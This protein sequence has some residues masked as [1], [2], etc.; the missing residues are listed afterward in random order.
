MRAVFFLDK[1][2]PAE[3]SFVDDFLN[4]FFRSDELLLVYQKALT[5]RAES[6]DTLPKNSVVA[7]HPRRGIKRFTNIF[8]VFRFLQQ[9]KKFETI[10]VR[11]CP[12]MLLGA[13]FFCLSRGRR[14]P[15][16]V[17]M[18]S[19]DHEGTAKGLKRWIALKLHSV[20][21]RK[22][23]GLLTVSASGMSRVRKLY[24]FASTFLVIPLCASGQV[25][26]DQDMKPACSRRV[27]TFIYG[28]SFNQC[29]KFDLVL[30]AFESMLVANRCKLLLVGV[31]D[32]LAADWINRYPFC[33]SP[34]VKFLSKL[35]RRDFLNLL[36]SA[37]FGLSLVPSSSVNDEMSPTKL[38]EYFDYSLPA[39]ASENVE[40]QR[41]VISMYGAGILTQ[42]RHQDIE[43][44]IEQAISA[45]VE[46]Y[47]RLVAGAQAAASAF[48]YAAY[49][50]P[51]RTLCH[52]SV[53]GEL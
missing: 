43:L 10:L 5:N 21:S 7:T 26:P 15:K 28:G 39:I 33:S 49:Q 41:Y 14:A 50:Q 34:N 51:F 3:H 35:P 16:L 36:S 42:F 44:A 53:E 20:F 12:A 6:S 37:D 30:E 4:V 27:R 47:A 29:R 2:Y 13:K 18:S 22:I 38:L 40:F 23:T 25:S 17:Y 9:N 52:G 48:S 1:C 24:P 31:D 32:M 19:F 11:N 45:S 46:E 8:S